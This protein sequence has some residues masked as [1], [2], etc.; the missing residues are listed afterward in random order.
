VLVDQTPKM[1][2]EG[3][4]QFGMY[5]LTWDVLD[6]FVASFGSP[7]AQMASRFRRPNA[8]SP[9]AEAMP[10]LVEMLGTPYPHDAV[11]PLLRDHAVQD[12]RDV[13]ARIDIPALAVG[14]RHSELWPVEHAEYLASTMKAGRLVILE[15]SGHAPMFT[16]PAE[17][18][19]AVLGFLNDL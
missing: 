12:W 1:M 7:D 15:H 13:V 17:F 18:N 3:D 9:A 19:A 6:E 11:R 10:L 4:W 5:D 14:G 16:E 2:N 8:L